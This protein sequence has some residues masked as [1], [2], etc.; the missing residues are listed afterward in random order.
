MFYNNEI[1]G[2]FTMMLSQEQEKRLFSARI[3]V[4]GVGGVGGALAHMLVRSGTQHIAV[5]DFDTIDISNINRQLI[6][7]QTNIGKFKVDEFEKQAKIINP[8]INV[9]KY[10][11][12]L[13][14]KTIDEINF[15][16]YD[17][18]VDCIDDVNA[19]KLLIKRKLYKYLYNKIKIF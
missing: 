5:V 7:D 6:A 14:E 10:P 8:N 1:F 13:D 4:F 17:Y 18:I 3:L 15:S 9:I 12:K 16:Q 2:R 11:L 19:K